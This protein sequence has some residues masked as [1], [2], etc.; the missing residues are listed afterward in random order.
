MVVGEFN[1]KRISAVK[2]EDN[3]PIRTHGD[4]PKAFQSALQRVQ[5][6]AGKVHGL[7]RLGFVEPSENVLNSV[8]QVG[9]YPPALPAL[10][11]PL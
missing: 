3:T 4:G 7:R 8:D 5:V 2:A 1:F 6:V 10:I 9:T 11:K